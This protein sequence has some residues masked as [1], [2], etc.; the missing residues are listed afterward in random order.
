M[1]ERQEWRLRVKEIPPS[2]THDDDDD[3]Y[4]DYGIEVIKT[5]S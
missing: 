4:D 3:D 5:T 1:D 2:W